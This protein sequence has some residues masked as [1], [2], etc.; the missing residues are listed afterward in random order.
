[1]LS[2][3]FI[4]PILLSVVSAHSCFI[5][6]YKWALPRSLSHGNYL[7]LGLNW[8]NEL[9]EFAFPP[10]KAW[11]ITQHC[12][13]FAGV[14]IILVVWNLAAKPCEGS[15]CHESSGDGFCSPSLSAKFRVRL[16]SLWSPAGYSVL[17]VYVSGTMMIQIYWVRG[18]HVT[19]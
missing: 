13:L 17:C 15:V 8:I 16:D 19:F 18:R 2:N 11:D 9:R 7:K 10:A 1:M 3:V 14:W 12:K 4:N 6:L 5:L